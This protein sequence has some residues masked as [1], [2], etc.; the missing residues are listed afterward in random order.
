MALVTEFI[1]FL[2]TAWS[3]Y[4][5]YTKSYAPSFKLRNLTDTT[6]TVTKNPTAQSVLRRRATQDK[7]ETPGSF[8]LAEVSAHDRPQ[9]CWIVV[10]D[11]VAPKSTIKDSSNNSNSN[12]GNK[13]GVNSSSIFSTAT[14]SLWESRGSRPLYD[15]LIPVCF[16]AGV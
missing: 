14:E 15:R 10:K 2:G 4:S 3:R 8:S 16:V 1:N 9:D 11:K 6:T 12:D 7:S 5:M 13:L